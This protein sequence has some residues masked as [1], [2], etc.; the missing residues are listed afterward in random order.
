M[1]NASKSSIKFSKNIIPSKSEAISSIIPYSSNQC[2]SLFLGLPILMGNSKKRAFQRIIDKVFGRIEGWKAKSL[3]QAGRLVLIKFVAAA[4]PSYAMSSF[5]LPKS[6]CSELDRIF[7]N[8]LWGFSATK[9]RNLSLK[10]WDSLCKP[11]EKGGLGLRRMKEVNLALISKLGWNLLNKTDLMWVSQLHCKY[12]N[13]C[14]FLS[15]LPFLPPHGYGKASSNPF[16]SF[17]KE[18]A[19][20]FIT[21]PLSLFGAPLGFPASPPLLLPLPLGFLHLFPTSGF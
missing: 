18:L 16:P 4:L 15:P 13:S 8:F 20:E 1:V 6:L 5:L 12:L 10:A 2:T 11:K 3:F 7:K 14:S 9:S 21:S 19:T 17:P